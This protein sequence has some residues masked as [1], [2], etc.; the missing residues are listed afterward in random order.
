M[1]TSRYPNP[2]ITPTSRVPGTTRTVTDPDR[3]ARLLAE[4]RTR[5]A[6][7]ARL[8]RAR[9]EFYAAQRAV[10]GDFALRPLRLIRKDLWD[11]GWDGAE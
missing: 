2:N 4:Y 5:K 3:L 7:D 8:A 9:A 6:A 1:P 10:S 11:A